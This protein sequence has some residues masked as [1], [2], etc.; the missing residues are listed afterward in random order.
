[1]K[2]IFKIVINKDDTTGMDA[3]S[4]VNQPAVERNFLKFS[5]EQQFKFDS[6]KHI[7]SGVVALADIPIYRFNYEIGEYWV[8]FD[9][10]TIQLM[11]EKYAKNGLLNNVNLQHNDNNFVDGIYL[12]ESYIINK[13]RGICPVE[14]QDIPDGSWI[15]SFKVEN[16]LLWE[17]IKNGKE[18]KGFS[19]Q[20]LFQLEEC[21]SSVNKINI[22]KELNQEIMK[23]SKIALRNLLLRFEDVNTD[24]GV[25]TIDG[26]MIE[27]AHVYVGEDIAPDGEYI[28]EDSKILVVTDGKIAEIKEAEQPETKE[29]PEEVQE[30]I[31]EEQKE[32]KKPIETEEQPSDKEK[33][34]EEEPK[35]GEQDNKDAKIAELE[36]KIA[37]LEADN[38]TLRNQLAEKDAAIVEKDEQ[39]KISV[40]KYASQIN[41]NK[42]NKIN[43]KSYLK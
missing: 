16:E 42:E 36:A 27:G 9:K 11:V 17:E 37:Q 23:L 21:F 10:E 32:E 40:E 31:Q 1:M 34:V 24:K 2:K 12:I 39:L 3:I 6:D 35:N 5:N 13:E 41:K 30:P 28:L 4:L 43:F 8:V 25:L 14:F 15:A 19:L 20:G 38:E 29:Q 7:I 22:I 26:E 18:L 33:P